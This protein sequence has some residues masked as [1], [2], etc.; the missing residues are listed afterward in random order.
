M[1]IELKLMKKRANPNAR[2]F[3]ADSLW[4]SKWFLRLC[5]A[6]SDCTHASFYQRRQ[7]LFEFTIKSASDGG[8][9]FLYCCNA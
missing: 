9:V 8:F 7:F 5:D 3:C 1:F 2:S 6:D 4:R